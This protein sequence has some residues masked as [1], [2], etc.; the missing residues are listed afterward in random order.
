MWFNSFFRFFV[1]CRSPLR[2]NRIFETCHNFSLRAWY[3]PRSPF[4]LFGWVC[5]LN[6]NNQSK[7][8]NLQKTFSTFFEDPFSSKNFFFSHTNLIFRCQITG[9][10]E[11]ESDR[12]SAKPIFDWTMTFATFFSHFKPDKMADF[13]PYHLS[14]FF[15]F[16]FDFRDFFHFEIFEDFR[17]P[18]VQLLFFWTTTQIGDFWTEISRNQLLFSLKSLVNNLKPMKKDNWRLFDFS[19]E[20]LSRTG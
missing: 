4:S 13:S 6:R 8:I 19:M 20:N 16:F 17:M 18:H 10:L 12:D 11:I 5:R 2:M 14:R 3:V 9:S 7:F 1:R 15:N